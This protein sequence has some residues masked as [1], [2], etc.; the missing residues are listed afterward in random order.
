MMNNKDFELISSRQNKKIKEFSKLAD[1]KYRRE[2]GLFL[3]EGVKLAG[4]AVDC[5]AAKYLLILGDAAEESAEKS[6]LDKSG[7]G[8]IKY[9]LT[10]PVFEKVSTERAPQGIIA[11]CSAPATDVSDAAELDGRRLIALDGIRDPGNLGTI[12]RTAYAFGYDAALLS[13][14]ADVYGHKTVRASMGAVFRLRAAECSD[15]AAFLCDLKSRGRRVIG[16][17]LNESSETFDGTGLDTTDVPVIGNEGHG[18]SQSVLDVCS[19][20]VKIPMNPRSESLN[21]AVAASVIMWE[22]SKLNGINN[23][24]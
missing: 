19:S 23:E 9:I 21:A 24:R 15:L 3:A 18:I 1:P 2:Y 13:D 6:V 4:E 5:G 22:Y 10:A 12:L 20:F 11:V 8:V 7:A 17:A 16:A 14:C